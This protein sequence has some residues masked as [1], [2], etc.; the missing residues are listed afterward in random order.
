MQEKARREWL[1]DFPFVKV[2]VVSASDLPA[3]D[4]D[5]SSD[6]YVVV[7]MGSASTQT[8]VVPKNLNPVFA[9]KAILPLCREGESLR[10]TCWDYDYLR[11]D[12]FLGKAALSVAEM[13]REE[14]VEYTAVLPLAR[15]ANAA[16]PGGSSWLS[17]GSVKIK[18]TR[19]VRDAREQGRGQSGGAVGA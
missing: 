10:V 11:A 5:G 2:E 18:L 6:P 4:L 9:H 13:L 17:Q 19:C 8:Q 14:G 1:P 12:D 3:G 7:Q 16:D 15:P